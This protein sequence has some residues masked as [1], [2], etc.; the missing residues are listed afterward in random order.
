[1]KQT[2]IVMILD[3]SGSMAGMES[4]TIGGFNAT[5]NAQKKLPEKARVTTVLFDDQY[6]MLH[7]GID[8]MQVPEMTEK[9]Y[10]VGGC[11]ALL[12]A[13]GRTILH[14]AKRQ[15]YARAE[16]RAERVLVV[17]ITDGMENASREYGAAQ[18]RRMIQRE[19]EKYHWEFL[20]LGA[21]MDAVTEARHYG[22]AA[23]RAVRYHNDS[24]GARLNYEAV[25]K[26]AYELRECGSVPE[27]W[28]RD[29]RNDYDSRKKK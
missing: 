3:R 24:R 21:N 22:I 14:V 2:E 8:L 1:M 6:Q 18:I 27:D 25:S 23:D 15:R 28:N 19:Q 13:V 26:V 5:I 29:I 11:T 17:I 10:Y 20:F 7:D 16:E 9:E 12:D 4:D